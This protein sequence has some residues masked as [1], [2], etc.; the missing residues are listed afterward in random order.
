MLISRSTAKRRK[1]LCLIQNQMM[2]KSSTIV[3]NSIGAVV[4]LK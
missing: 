1:I 3:M 4:I 2:G